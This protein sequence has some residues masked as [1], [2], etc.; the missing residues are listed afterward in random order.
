MHLSLHMAWLEGAFERVGCPICTLRLGHERDWLEIFIYDHSGDPGVV[1]MLSQSRGFCHRHAWAIARSQEPNGSIALALTY[2]SLIRGL[3]APRGRGSFLGRRGAPSR[4][5]DLWALAPGHKCPACDAMARTDGIYARVFA[6]SLASDEFLA[7]YARSEGLCLAH[8]NSVLDATLA[9][10]RRGLL[11]AH[12]AKLAGATK[13]S[14]ARAHPHS[15]PAQWMGPGLSLLV[16]ADPNPPETGG[17]S[18]G[19]PA[20]WCRIC[21]MVREAETKSV[22]AVTGGHAAL[23]AGAWLC[24]RHAWQACRLMA[25][26]PGS[27]FEAWLRGGLQ[28]ALAE[29]EAREARLPDQDTR[30]PERGQRAHDDRPLLGGR[31]CAVCA[32]VEASVREQIAASTGAALAGEVCLRHLAAYHSILELD[33]GRHAEAVAATLRELA[34]DLGEFIRKSSWEWRHEPKGREQDSWRRAITL[35]VGDA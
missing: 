33:A 14:L 21:D 22:A 35:F 11:R 10:T 19:P 8:L 7:L 2:E 12:V 20:A 25:G 9:P 28:A 5:R 24:A 6:R 15:L 31:G 13:P 30:R 17:A 26:R 18:P 32:A 16:G 23:P 1:H 34:V 4:R 29:C 27:A 3:L